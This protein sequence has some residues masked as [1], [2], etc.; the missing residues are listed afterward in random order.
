MAIN[1][2]D[3]HGSNADDLDKRVRR[4]G[5][6]LRL[7]GIFD[8]DRRATRDE[9]NLRQRVLREMLESEIATLE[10][11]SGH[12]NGF[13]KTMLIWLNKMGLDS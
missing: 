6:R 5:D 4:A 1:E 13:Q 3:A 11:R 8:R 12:V 2:V 10:A 7:I 9:R